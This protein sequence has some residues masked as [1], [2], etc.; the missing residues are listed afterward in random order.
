MRFDYAIIGGGFFGCY[1]ALELRRMH[2]DRSVVILEREPDLMRRASYNNQARIHNGYHY[3]RSLLTALRSHE[4][5]DR[6]VSEFGPCVDDKFEKYYAIGRIQSK[7]TAAQ[8]ETFIKRVGSP[9]ER[10]APEIRRMFSKDYIEDVFKVREYA[11]DAVVLK[12][13]VAKRLENAQVKVMLH[14]EV[15][16]VEQ[17]SSG[18]DKLRVNVR[19]RQT[20]RKAEIDANTAFVC[21]YNTINTILHRSGFQTIPLKHE[22]TE[23]AV[24]RVPKE[25]EKVGVTVMCG[26]FFSFMPFPPLGLHTLSHVRYTP[27]TYWYDSDGQVDNE[28]YF[29]EADRDSAFLCMKKDA[30][31]Y[32][33][34][35]ADFKY[36]R[37][38]WE[39]K[40]VLPKSEAD[41][42]RPILFRKDAGGV[43][44]LHCVMGGKIDNVYDLW[45]ELR[46]LP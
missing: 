32:M 14:T 15:E 23:M 18:Q 25:L 21:T 35:V 41:D 45:E 22:W 37:S 6:F 31:R 5:F 10:A 46:V 8:Y 40:T 19:D 1:L 38:I 33:P 24:V 12:K 13:L 27:H 2:P 7:V 11:F 36:E 43:E 20:K 39:I 44:N 17:I 42:S 3:P 16:T 29:E 28:K 26:P 34:A 30:S 9:I 4:N